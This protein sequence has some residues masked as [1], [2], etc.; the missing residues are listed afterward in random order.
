MIVAGI[1]NRL[2]LKPVVQAAAVFMFLVA[3]GL[4]L[5]T[6]SEKRANKDFRTLACLMNCINREDWT[7]ITGNRDLNYQNYL[8]LNCLNLALSHQGK[9]MTDLFRYPQKG[10]QS[11]M[12]GYQAYNDLNVLFSHIYYHTGVISEALC[13]SFGTMIATTY[14]NPT[15]LKLLVKELTFKRI[16][17]YL[18]I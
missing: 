5:Y 12:V 10:A 2:Q 15:L 1:S 7:G 8:H 16:A 14:G 4:F 17:T 11:L 18:F 3:G 6:Q 13:L 9:M